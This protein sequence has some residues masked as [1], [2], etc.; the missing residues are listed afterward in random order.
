MYDDD[1]LYVA[2]WMWDTDGKLVTRLSRRDTPIPDIDLFAIHLD[3]YHSHRS[4]Y[5][6]TVSALGTIR[7]IAAG[8]GLPLTGGDGSWNPVWDARTRI[9]DQGWFLE[10][11]IPFSQLRFSQEE[12]QVWGLQIERKLRP[13]QENT[14][15]SF[16]RKTDPN[17]QQN[18]GHL[19]GIRGIKP[20]SRLELAP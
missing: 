10:M 20:G 19:V 12:E 9:T 13:Q 6:F 16:T 7:D 15:W 18:F 14:I 3:T 8:P 5:R 17:G 1:A 4:S 11:R 2:G